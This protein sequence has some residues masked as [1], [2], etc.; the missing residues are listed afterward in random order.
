VKNGAQVRLNMTE[1]ELE[2]LKKDYNDVF[3]EEVRKRLTRDT[4]FDKERFQRSQEVFMG[5]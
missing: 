2:E 1:N 5:K 4:D 3:R